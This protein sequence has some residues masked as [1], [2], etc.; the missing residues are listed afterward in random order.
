MASSTRFGVF[1]FGLFLVASSLGAQRPT[2]VRL[3]G[4]PAPMSLDSGSVDVTLPASAGAAF[5]FARQAF[6]ELKI[7]T[8]FAD[9]ARGYLIN[10][11]FIKL[12]SLAGFPLSTYM[13][14]GA[15]MT[16]PNA[17]AWRVT[18]AIAALIDATGP[19]TSRLR[20]NVLAGA[21]SVEGVS[22]SAVAC[23]TTGVLEDRILETIRLKI[24][25]N[26]DW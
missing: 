20:L 26:R 6:F 2:A 3:P 7:P 14:C 15:G 21:E 23:G 12:R 1:G 24:R 19:S 11:R 9:S 10:G 16:G 25:V 5:F 22:K 8:P 13:N 4:H 18:M 17:D